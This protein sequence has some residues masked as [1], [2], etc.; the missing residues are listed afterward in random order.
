MA[1][2]RPYRPKGHS[3]GHPP[4]RQR[5]QSGPRPGGSG[6]GPRPKPGGGPGA[7]RPSTG[8]PKGHA[9]H[10]A[11]AK[12]GGGTGRRDRAGSGGPEPRSRTNFEPGKPERLQKILAQ[13]GLGSRRGCEELI[14]QGRVTVDG[15]VVR[16][17]GT[18]VDPAAKIAVDAEPIRLEPMV[19]YAVNKP[20]GYVSTNFD[21]SGRPRVVDLVPDIPERVYTVGRLDED[22]TGLMILTNDGELANRLAHPRFGVE[23][24]YRALVAGMPAPDTLSKLT[25]GVWLSDG[26]VRAKRA[27]IAGRQGQATVLELVLAEG[28]KREI[29]RMLAKLGHKVMSLT[30]MAVGPITLKGLPVGECRPLTR[31]EVELLHKVASG[32]SV[33]VPGFADERP[34]RSPR[35]PSKGRHGDQP[36]A[37]GRQGDQQPERGRDRGHAHGASHGPAPRH[38]GVRPSAGQAHGP[39]PRPGG[40]RPAGTHAHG[41]APRPGGGRPAGA[42]RPADAAR[43]PRHRPAD[44]DAARP[45]RHRPADADAR[46]PVPG[47]A[48]RPP[49]GGPKRGPG[50]PQPVARGVQPAGPR[51]PQEGPRGPKRP[52]GPTP[53]AKEP[54]PRPVKAPAAKPAEETTPR[55]RI[56]GL[57]GPAAAA[58]GGPPAGR[59]RPTARKPR[60]PRSALEQRPGRLRPPR[61]KDD[62]DNE[63]SED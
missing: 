60:P 50:G 48:G 46:P 56:I 53:H 32:V 4:S 26:K 61:P 35:G 33:S 55:R 36:A 34:S 12:P 57:V 24:L 25:E 29:R 62:Q 42:P 63:P 5:R 37:R 52:A 43:P 9:T 6:P 23:K 2:Q 39:S 30:R 51:G 16:E 59:K 13:A 47:P 1:K 19:Y 10:R 11:A 14:L 22:S 38:G 49:A 21:P 40:G 27:R 41:P 15:Q 3:S 18:K 54:T 7:R 45:P 31:H 28:K 58:L 44:V 8:G 20:E 17:L